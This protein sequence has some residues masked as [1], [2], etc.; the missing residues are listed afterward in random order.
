M[1]GDPGYMALAGGRK[2]LLTLL[3]AVYVDTVDERS[4]ILIHTKPAFQSP[5]EIP[6]TRKG[7]DVT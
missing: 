6:R 1:E 7:S 5:F 2:L 3:E 4:I